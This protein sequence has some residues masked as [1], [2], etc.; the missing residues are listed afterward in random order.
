VD[1]VISTDNVETAR[2]MVEAGLG[3][4]LLPDMFIAQDLPPQLWRSCVEPPISRRIVMA[5]WKHHQMSLAAAAF[6]KELRRYAC[7][8]KSCMEL[9]PA[10]IPPA[11][12]R[13]LA[14]LPIPEDPAA[15]GEA[16]RAVR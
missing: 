3:V 12:Q 2:K 10:D 7:E 6:M 9:E 16:L 5:T 14:A 8:W 4:A 15:E 1:T 13:G 11:P